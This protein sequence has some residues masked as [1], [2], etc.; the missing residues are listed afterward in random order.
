MALLVFILGIW[1][2][3]LCQGALIPL[4]SDAQNILSETRMI[5]GDDSGKKIMEDINAILE[6]YQNNALVVEILKTFV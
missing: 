2:M 1:L 3:Q 5:N 4:N 6:K